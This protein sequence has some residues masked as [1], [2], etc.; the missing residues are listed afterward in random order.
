M[1]VVL[2]RDQWRE[3]YKCIGR[4]GELS[5]EC[6][7]IAAACQTTDLDLIPVEFDDPNM[8]LKLGRMSKQNWI[9]RC[10]EAV[11]WTE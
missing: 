7:A 5:N 4:C 9:V 1:R 6:E 2:T 8:V 3:V 10:A 11:L